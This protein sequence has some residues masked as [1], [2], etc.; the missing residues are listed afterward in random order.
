MI[1]SNR[2]VDRGGTVLPLVQRFDTPGSVDSVSVTP[3]ADSVLP[4]DVSNR[5]RANTGVTAMSS[6]PA[7][8]SSSNSTAQVVCSA[9]IPCVVDG[10]ISQNFQSFALYASPPTECSYSASISIANTHVLSI[11]TDVACHT[12]PP[13]QPLATIGLGPAECP[14]LKDV[15]MLVRQIS[16]MLFQGMVLLICLS[17]KD[18]VLVRQIS[19]ML[20]QG[21]VLLVC[22][23][24]SPEVVV[25]LVCQTGPMLVQGMILL[26]HTVHF[27]GLNP[28]NQQSGSSCLGRFLSLLPRLSYMMISYCSFHDDFYRE[29]AERATSS[30]IHNVHFRDLDV[31]NQQSG[32]CCLGRFLSLLPRL[33]H[34]T[35]KR[36]SFSDDFYREIA[37]RASSSQIHTVRFDGLNLVNQQSG[38]CCLGR[39]LSLLPRLAEMMIYGC[40]F[41]DDFYREIA[42]RATSSLIH[43][44]QLN[45]LDVVNQQSGSCCLG[46]FLSLLPRLTDLTILECS[47]HDN[48]YREIAERASSSQV[49]YTK[50]YFGFNHKGI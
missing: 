38:S 28:V 31:V 35:I 50:I 49:R 47:F 44:V 2:V 1:G 41:H 3:S 15:I 42:E 18:V 23:S 8:V 9:R 43:T 27:Y 14:L 33:I 46:R 16:P 11:W 17:L 32:S 36:C 45:S 21:M 29:I 19:P 10:L 20:V 25:A 40:S 4:F 12:R 26:I 5:Y 22:L 13:D 6:S 24:W 39:F 34:L 37:E 7:N 30:L 48:F